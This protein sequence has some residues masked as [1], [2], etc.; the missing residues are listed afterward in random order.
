MFTTPDPHRVDGHVT[1]TR[2]LEVYGAMIDGIRVEFSGGKAVRL[3]AEMGGDTLRSIA[4]SDEGASRLGELALVDGEG[5]IGPLGTVFYDTLIDENSASHIALGSAYD[6]GVER[7]RGQGADQ[8]QP[9]PRRLHDRLRPSSTSTA[10]P[11][12]A[13]PSRCSATAPGSSRS[14]SRRARLGD[15]DQPLADL[16]GPGTEIVEPRQ[17]RE[18]SSPKTRSKSGVTL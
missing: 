15:R 1:A 14:G 18:D 4:A 11:P 17:R 16:L 3:D 6:L 10:S 9:H 12:T 5:R 13:R 7:R 2:P 8:P